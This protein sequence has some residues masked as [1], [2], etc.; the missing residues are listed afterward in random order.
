MALSPKEIHE[1]KYFATEI[2]LNTLETLNHLG[3][4]HYG[5]SLSVVEILAVLY[6]KVMDMT[7]EQFKKKDRDT[8]SYL[9]DMQVP[10]YIVPFI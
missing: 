9:K 2:R 5:G 6:G 10:L 3:F 7:P 4:G 8:L 1:L